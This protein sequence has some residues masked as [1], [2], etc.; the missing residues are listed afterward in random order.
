MIQLSLLAVAVAAQNPASGTAGEQWIELT[1]PEGRV[2]FIDVGS[3][4][5]VR[6]T[7]RSVRTRVV[8]DEPDSTGRARTEYVQDVDC[9]TRAM[10]LTGFAT[11]RSDGSLINQG[12]APADVRQW[13]RFSPGSQGAVTVDRVCR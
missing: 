1:R 4:H 11:Y 9:E 6:G 2:V 13:T 12:S 7:I 8:T 3:I 10:A 5:V